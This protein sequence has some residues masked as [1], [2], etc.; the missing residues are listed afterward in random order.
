MPTQ[1]P[2]G[3]ARKGLARVTFPQFNRLSPEVRL[4][5]W[6]EFILTPRIIRIDLT[7]K[8]DK[9][10]RKGQLSIKIDGVTREQVCPLLGVCYESRQAALKSLLLFTSR[11][12][13]GLIYQHC[14]RHFAIRSW[15]IVFFS[16][17][18]FSFRD[19]HTEGDTET[20]GNIMLG[21]SAPLLQGGYASRRLKWSIFG[22]SAWNLVRGL[23]NIHNLK[24]IYCLVH[25]SYTSALP[26]FD[27]D[28]IGELD[29]DK[30]PDCKEKLVE[31]VTDFHQQ[32]KWDRD[33]PTPS[34]IT[35]TLSELGL[36]PLVRERQFLVALK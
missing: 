11:Y 4:M 13:S 33:N 24:N 29:P 14:C 27:L 34:A 3:A 31:W 1:A 6:E 25:N 18:K 26:V 23:N 22:G 2:G 35:T 20:I 12:G 30:F 17:S 32:Q 21:A 8:Y 19:L 10:H 7:T 28:R 16:G 9:K 36:A 15:D 5:I